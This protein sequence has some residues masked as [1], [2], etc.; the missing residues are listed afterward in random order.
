[1]ELEG[2]CL[3]AA[4]QEPVSL[5]MMGGRVV[6]VARDHP[7]GVVTTTAAVNDWKKDSIAD[8]LETSSWL[9]G[10]ELYNL[11]VM[12]DVMKHGVLIPPEQEQLVLEE[13]MCKVAVAAAVWPLRPFEAPE[14]GEVS[15][16]RGVAF[17]SAGVPAH[18]LPRLL[19]GKLKKRDVVAVPV[20]RERLPST[21]AKWEEL[22]VGSA[23]GDDGCGILVILETTSGCLLAG[24]SRGRKGIP[25]ERVGEEAAAA[26]L[27]VLSAKGCGDAQ[28]EEQLLWFMAVAAG[29][30]RL[31]MGTVQPTPGTR[32]TLEL[33]MR[34]GVGARLAEPDASGGRLV[35]VQGIGAMLWPRS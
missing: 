5:Y 26:A 7:V 32:T 21:P 27:A 24:G 11:P 6:I 30:S 22:E 10:P 3:Q 23:A 2:V 35:E 8:G 12:T 14:R 29:T 18:V 31:R 28:L 33:L 9:N 17:K 1:M 16:A 13:T 20:L 15:E 25:A 19:E 4:A 34:L